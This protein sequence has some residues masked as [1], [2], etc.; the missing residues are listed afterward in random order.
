MAQLPVLAV[1]DAILSLLEEPPRAATASDQVTDSLADW[2]H[3]KRV[4]LLAAWVRSAVDNAP[5]LAKVSPSELNDV[6]CRIENQYRSGALDP[7]QRCQLLAW[8]AWGNDDCVRLWCRLLKQDPP[9]HEE[10]IREVLAPLFRRPDPPV[11]VLFPDLLEAISELGLA[12]AILDLANYLYR[13]KHTRPHPASAR[14]Q[15]LAQLLAN[16][17]QQLLKVEEAPLAAGIPSERVS[18][19]I[20]DSVGLISAL[21]DF[22]AL[23][24]D[25]TLVAKLYPCLDLRHRR[26]QVE[27]AYA[28]ATLGE[29]AGKERLVA[30]AEEPLVRRRVLAYAEPLGLLN[31]VP[32]EFR[33]SAALAESDLVLSLAHPQNLGLAPHTTKLLDQRTQSWPG[34][35]EPV[36]CFLIEFEYPFTGNPYRNV[37]IV[38]PVTHSF[39]TVL[40]DLTVE[41]LYAVFAGWHVSHPEIYAVEPAQFGPQQAGTLARLTRRLTD[42]A[43]EQV[44]PKLLGY[45][46]DEWILVGRGQ[47]GEDSGWAVAG[48]D[49]PL[50]L[51]DAGG[52]ENLDAVLVWYFWVGRTLLRRFNS[53]SE[54]T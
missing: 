48:P 31:D 44:E 45:F 12:T 3:Q 23:Q 46:F 42:Q 28:L 41:D 29:A 14:L 51:P 36:E 39:A 22:L 40:S 20:N 6:L 49:E 35:E 5:R 13:K 32:A 4:S 53:I 15:P 43:V 10:G 33:E 52:F 27:A 16:V 50:W 21:C 34:F 11:A 26:V 9:Q 54:P 8:L 17:T 18:H 47:R 19:V 2:P 37:G 30:L 1:A 25:A 24:G 7:Q 38:G